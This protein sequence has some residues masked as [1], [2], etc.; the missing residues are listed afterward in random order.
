MNSPSFRSEILS[1][2]DRLGTADQHRV[3]DFVKALAASQPKGTPGSEVV[4]LAGIIASADVDEMMA[5]IEAGCE[6]VDADEW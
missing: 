3:L 2:I 1:E 6:K 5:A 4:R